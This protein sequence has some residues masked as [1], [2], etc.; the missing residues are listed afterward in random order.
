M[1]SGGDDYQKA[2]VDNFMAVTGAGPERASFFLG[3]A[4]WNLQVL[5]QARAKDVNYYLLW[6]IT[7]GYNLAARLLV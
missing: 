5:F 1:A 6:Y 4:A 3:S 7:S 2:L